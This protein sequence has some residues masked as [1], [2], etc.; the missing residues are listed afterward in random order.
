MKKNILLVLGMLAC[1]LAFTQNHRVAFVT[2]LDADG[3]FQWSKDFSGSENICPIKIFVNE[4]NNLEIIAYSESSFLIDSLELERDSLFSGISFDEEGSLIGIQ[5]RG[6]WDN[7]RLC[8]TLG[9]YVVLSQLFSGYFTHNNSRIKALGG[10]DIVVQMYNDNNLIWTKAIV[11]EGKEELY[12]TI[13]FNNN[14]YI[15]GCTVYAE[16]SQKR[17]MSI[18]TEI[19]NSHN[20]QIY[21]NPAISIISIK[22]NS[23]KETIKK[24]TLYSLN[25]KIVKNV[26]CDLVSS[27]S[28]DVQDVASANYILEVVTDVLTYK[29]NVT[30][31]H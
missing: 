24:V 20:I 23:K 5:N 26:M 4:S 17:S 22:T 15:I 7:F 2:K 16:N 6:G 31:A 27:V 3:E 21:P 28:I 18:R 8:D 13:L 25:G 10:N 12:G 30:I 9:D 11:T 19:S 29:K 1:T 14:I